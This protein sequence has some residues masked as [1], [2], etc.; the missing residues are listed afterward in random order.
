MMMVLWV[1]MPLAC[2]IAAAIY[3]YRKARGAAP[4]FLP[5]WSRKKRNVVALLLAAVLFY[6]DELNYGEQRL[7]QLQAIVTFGI[8]G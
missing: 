5:G 3:L 1:I 2:M 8:A 4:C 7:W 6:F